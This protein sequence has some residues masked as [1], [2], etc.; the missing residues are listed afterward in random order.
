MTDPEPLISSEIE[1]QCVSR[2]KSKNWDTL[3]I[4]VTVL[5]MSILVLQMEHFVQK[6]QKGWQTVYS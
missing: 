6:I 3:I 2:K 1:R 4:T 5:K